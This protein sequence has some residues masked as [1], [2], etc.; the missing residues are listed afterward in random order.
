MVS[1]PAF[2]S[3]SCSIASTAFTFYPSNSGSSVRTMIFLVTMS[4]ITASLTLL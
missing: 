2:N 1:R 3:V 4:I